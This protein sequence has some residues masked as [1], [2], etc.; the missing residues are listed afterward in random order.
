MAP[1][2]VPAH[3][4]L[5]MEYA[6]VFATPVV[7]FFAA[8][9]G[10]W[11]AS[12]LTEAREAKKEKLRVEK[13]SIYIAI[14]LTA[15]LE[16]VVSSC[17]QVAF[18]DGTSEGYPAGKDRETYEATTSTPAFDPLE[19][20]AD[21]RIL[22]KALMQGI[23]ELP[24]K[25][26][27]LNNRHEAIAENE[28]PWDRLE[29]FQARMYDFAKL[30]IDTTT[31]MIDLRKYAGIPLKEFTDGEWSR[32]EMFIQKIKQIDTLR[33][34]HSKRQQAVHREITSVIAD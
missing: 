14:L 15:H 9:L 30:G 23:L 1:D 16:R 10:L 27:Q 34:E 18:D 24:H 2:Q 25:I 29:S 6:K 12:K 11:V 32:S 13:E 31:L 8:I 20:E 5:W 4:P 17:L 26:E 21:W 3:L 19:I 28:A 7:S 22:P 33:L